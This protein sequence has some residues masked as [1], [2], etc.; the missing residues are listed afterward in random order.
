MLSQTGLVSPSPQAHRRSRAQLSAAVVTA[1]GDLAAGKSA[2]ASG[3][4]QHIPATTLLRAMER[5]DALDPD[6]DACAFYDGPPGLLLLHRL[7]LVLLVVLVFQSGLGV[8]KV[9]LVLTLAGLGRR[10]ACSPSHLRGKVVA[11][12][13]LMQEFEREQTAALGPTMPH[14][15]LTL[16][17]DEMFR[18][19]KMILTAPDPVTG[20]LLV[21]QTADH[22]DAITWADTIR[23]GTQGLN[24]TLVALCADRAGGIQSAAEQLLGVAFYPELFHVQHGLRTAFRRPVQHQLTS[25]HKACSKAAGKALR[26]GLPPDAETPNI[27]PAESPALHAA[28]QALNTA[29]EAWRHAQEAHQTLGEV[30]R[31][32]SLALHPVCLHT[33]A[34]LDP[35]FVE[36]TVED[37]FRQLDPLAA[38]LGE[39]CEKALRSA[40]EVIPA[41]KNMVTQWH[42]RVTARVHQEVMSIE[43]RALLRTCLIPA[44]YLAWVSA[45]NHLPAAVRTYLRARSDEMFRSVAAHAEWKELP[46]GLRVHL[47]SVA[48]DCARLFVRSSSPTEG[49]NAWTSPRLFRHHGVRDE[50]L[51]ALKVVHN[52]LLR[53][54]DGTT[55]GQRFYGRPHEDLVEYLCARMPLPP[56]PRNRRPKPRPDPLQLAA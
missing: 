40:R 6:P 50:W 14:R 42:A 38:R 43:L 4:A 53:R 35:D 27:D 3:A 47:A 5:L 49:H 8:D 54:A 17:P 46:H 1:R 55:A 31:K 44:Y 36:G 11:M 41:W 56:L 18:C 34:L 10:V 29:Q 37:L 16:S 26:L 45:R 20:M 13:R 48:R 22:R 7:V 19:R 12:C 39:K 51:A 2:R 24:I 23:C 28:V 15:D 52:F 25:A 33:G 32:L 30:N 9:R 21:H